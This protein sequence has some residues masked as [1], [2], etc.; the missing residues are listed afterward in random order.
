MIIVTII[1]VMFI[2]I[3]TGY[4]HYSYI[5]RYKFEVLVVFWHIWTWMKTTPFDTMTLHV[6]QWPVRKVRFPAKAIPALHKN[7]LLRMKRCTK[8]NNWTGRNVIMIMVLSMLSSTL[9]MSMRIR[10]NSANPAL[11]I[12]RKCCRSLCSVNRT[13][14]YHWI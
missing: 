4:Y 8:K 1:V 14:C 9:N 3:I 12:K 5:C 11:N 13:K 10:S 7:H 2:A 6:W